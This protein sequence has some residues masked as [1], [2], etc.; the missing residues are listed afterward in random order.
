MHSG[1][2]Q[3]IINDVFRLTEN[4]SPN[5]LDLKL[6][7]IASN[8]NRKQSRICLHKEDIS[9]VQ[10]MY[11]CH[12]KNC[13]VKIHKH[14]D[15]PEW[16]MFINAESNVIYYDKEGVEIKR[17]YFDTNKSNGPIFHLIPN[18]VWHK[19]EFKKDSFFLEIKQGPF[20]QKNTLYL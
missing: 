8:S 1:Y 11:I 14:K 2:F 10:I 13:E 15:F 5:D 17:I 6:K 7:E 12:L 4:T 16:I 18:D 9:A 19:I 3:K 20:N